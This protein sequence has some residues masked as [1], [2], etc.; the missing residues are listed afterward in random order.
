MLIAVS[1]CKDLP[2]IHKAEPLYVTGVNARRVFLLLPSIGCREILP[3]DKNR[4]L[5]ST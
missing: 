1:G 4:H 5:R 3:W 2:S